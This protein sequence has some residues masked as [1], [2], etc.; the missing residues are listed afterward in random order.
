MT[1]RSSLEATHRIFDEYE[2]YVEVRIEDEEISIKDSSGDHVSMDHKTFCTIACH[3]S[4]YQQMVTQSGL[5]E[6]S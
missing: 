6:A 3:F 1:T 4:R 5:A 2:D